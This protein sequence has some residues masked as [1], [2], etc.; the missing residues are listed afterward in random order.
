MHGLV[1]Q[2]KFMELQ[3]DYGCSVVVL[4]DH[5]QKCQIGDVKIASLDLSPCL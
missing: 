1:S 3:S 5:T 2:G 4:I